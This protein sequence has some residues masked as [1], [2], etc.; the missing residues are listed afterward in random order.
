MHFIMIKINDINIYTMQRGQSV[1]KFENLIIH[2]LHVPTYEYDCMYE[3]L[4]NFPRV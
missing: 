1:S 4:I 2:I 3:M